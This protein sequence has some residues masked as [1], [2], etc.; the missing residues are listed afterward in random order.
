MSQ[1]LAY[2]WL[3]LKDCPMEKVGLY[4]LRTCLR[5]VRRQIRCNILTR[6]GTCYVV[7]LIRFL[8]CLSSRELFS[9]ELRSLC[10]KFGEHASLGI[11]HD[12]FRLF[13]LLINNRYDKPETRVYGRIIHNLW[14]LQ[15]GSENPQ[16][17][18]EPA[19]L[20]YYILRTMVKKLWYHPRRCF[21]LRTIKYNLPNPSRELC[22]FSCLDVASLA[23]FIFPPPV[24]NVN[25]SEFTSS[26]YA[27]SRLIRSKYSWSILHWESSHCR[28]RWLMVCMIGS[29]NKLIVHSRRSCV[30]ANYEWKLMTTTIFLKGRNIE[31]LVARRKATIYHS[32]SKINCQLSSLTLCPAIHGIF[33]LP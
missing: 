26:A 9:F 10:L 3:N 22:P 15:F 31:N 5:P 20:V 24:A 6:L 23:S 12:V 28:Q 29:F 8:A 13:F 33:S 25:R 18:I 7:V 27:L 1:P 21:F 14:L 19:W 32:D 4:K 30:Q 11:L 16:R 17:Q 2:S